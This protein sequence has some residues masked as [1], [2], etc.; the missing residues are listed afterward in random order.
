LV[1][2]AAGRSEVDNA[3]GAVGGT[4]DGRAADVLDIFEGDT[5]G[6]DHATEDGSAE[7]IGVRIAEMAKVGG[8]G[9]AAPG[10]GVI[11]CE[12]GVMPSVLEHASELLV[13][14]EFPIVQM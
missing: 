2:R 4:G 8:S 5:V 10:A 14:L 9:E 1:H 12:H 3:T 7:D 13:L 6:G 11:A